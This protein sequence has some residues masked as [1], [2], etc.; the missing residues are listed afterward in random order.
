MSVDDRWAISDTLAEYAYRWD[1]KD[2]A[3][4]ARLFTDDAAIDWVLGGE[5]VGQ[6]VRGRADIEAYAR[7]AHGDRIGEKQ[8]RHH[9]S[10]LA[11]RELG[12][13][14][15]VTDNTLLVTHQPPGG[16]IEVKSS[17]VYRITWA[18]IDGDWLISRRTLHVDR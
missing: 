16:T 18:K 2:A 10:N 4:F 11:F 1:A 14:T 13:D 12:T 5:P 7:Q 15:A 9:F 6:T 3:G 8:S 17:G